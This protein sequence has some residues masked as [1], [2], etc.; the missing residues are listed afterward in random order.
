MLYFYWIISSCACY[1]DEDVFA[2]ERLE[3][4][5]TYQGTCDLGVD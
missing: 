2:D 1:I 5:V 4:I 3:S